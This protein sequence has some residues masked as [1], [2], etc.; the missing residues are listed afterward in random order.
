MQPLFIFKHYAY[1]LERHCVRT[2][3][4]MY[5]IYA[6]RLIEVPVSELLFSST[7]FIIRIGLIETIYVHILGVINIKA[8]EKKNIIKFIIT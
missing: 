4:C 6:C 3:I 8:C 7:R 1:L 2:H 5:L